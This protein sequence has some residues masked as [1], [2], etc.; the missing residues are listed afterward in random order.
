MNAFTRRPA[1]RWLVPSAAAVLLAGGGSAV[2]LITANAGDGL[3]DRSPS[4]LLVDVQNARVD[5]LSGTIVQNA[6]LGLPSLPGVG[7]SGSSD[8]T[9]LISGSH[10]LRLWYA[11]PDKVRLA[12]LGS[13]G[14]S[15]L[16]RNGADLWSW[17]S[18]D[19]TATHRD[20][21]VTGGDTPQSLSSA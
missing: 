1:L 18:K 14:E 4:Q 6:D 15:D 2:G 16:V 12:L 7:G 9:S 20:V 3:P 10:T 11:G 8:L 13:L 21:G 17:S 19:K 5:G